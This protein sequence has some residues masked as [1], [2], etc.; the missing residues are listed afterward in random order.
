MGGVSMRKR[1]IEH[2][3]RGTPSGEPR[4]WLDLEC[5]IE[6][7]VTSEDAAHPI[8]SALVASG[9]RGW[10]AEGPGE[11]TVRLLFGE[12]TKLRRV[13]LEFREEVQGRTQEFVLSWSA[14]GGRMYR[15]IVRQQYTFSPPGTVREIEEYAVDLD[16]VTALELRIVPDIGGGDA[17]ASLERMQLASR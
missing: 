11:Q 15:E 2:G 9:A 8:E 6:I 14:D 7:E 3:P 10:R 16:G 5:L 12:P 13:R 17:R 1:I 4:D